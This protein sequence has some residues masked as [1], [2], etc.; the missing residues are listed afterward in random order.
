MCEGGGGDLKEE[1]L[2]R[3]S[4]GHS[5]RQL[6]GSGQAAGCCINCPNSVLDCFVGALMVDA[7]DFLQHIGDGIRNILILEQ[8]QR[9]QVPESAHQP[10]SA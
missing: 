10:L 7:R 5:V 2:A 3:D 1:G 6:Q 9:M 8:L 4:R